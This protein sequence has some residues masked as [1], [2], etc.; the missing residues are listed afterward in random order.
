MKSDA[1]KKDGNQLLHY[2]PLHK[3]NYGIETG[4][5]IGKGLIEHFEC[6]DKLGASEYC[7]EKRPLFLMFTCRSPVRISITIV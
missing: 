7:S 3:T 4:R 5:P 1:I 2:T 6:Y